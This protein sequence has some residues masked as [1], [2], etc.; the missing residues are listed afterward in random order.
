MR[1]LLGIRQYIIVGDSVSK[2]NLITIHLRKNRGNDRWTNSLQFWL[3]R[4]IIFI[5]LL[6][7]N[8]L[9]IFLLRIICSIL[10]TF[11]YWAESKYQLYLFFCGKWNFCYWISKFLYN[12]GIM[13]SPAHTHIQLFNQC[14]SCA[15]LTAL[16]GF[17]S[18][19]KSFPLCCKAWLTSGVVFRIPLLA[20]LLLVQNLRRT[21]INSVSLK[22]CSNWIFCQSVG[23]WL[24][25]VTVQM[26]RI[27]LTPWD[28]PAS[29][30]NPISNQVQTN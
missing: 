27:V 3:Q 24:T 16:S 12:A 29:N 1:D 8:I 4:C 2:R 5:S 21:E 30:N 22:S 13:L 20:I 25:S 19:S 14:Y 10:F 11:T 18:T 7:S 23:F 26:F 15:H 9:S 6:Y 28:R 17:I